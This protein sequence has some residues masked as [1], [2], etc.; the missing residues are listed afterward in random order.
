MRRARDAM[1]ALVDVYRANGSEMVSLFDYTLHGRGGGA[2]HRARRCTAGRRRPR[3]PSAPRLRHRD[4]HR[5]R[6][7]GTDQADLRRPRGVDSVAA[8]GLSAGSGHRRR[9][10][11]QPAGD[12][13]H[14]RRPRHHGVGN[15]SHE[16]EAN[17]LEIIAT[18]ERYIDPNSRPSRS[19]H[20]SPATNPSK[21]ASAPRPPRSR[22]SCRASRPPTTP[23]S[24]TS[25]TSCGRELPRRDRASA[26]GCAGHQLSRSLPA[27]QGQATG[28]RPAVRCRRRGIE[29]PPRRATCPLP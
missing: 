29:N 25:P 27:D 20:R 8:P 6:R 3:R 22:R 1:S 18:A 24:G 12:R 17:S 21:P 26:A 19:A 5:R 15:T 28:A 4:C 9:A 2:V 7:R 10:E 14:P 13:N 16:A 11:A 23:R